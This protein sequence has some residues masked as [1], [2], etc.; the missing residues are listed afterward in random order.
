[1]FLLFLSYELD[2]NKLNR[3]RKGCLKLNLKYDK[4]RMNRSFLA[5]FEITSVL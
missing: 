3:Y 1:M 4:K 2:M 5:N